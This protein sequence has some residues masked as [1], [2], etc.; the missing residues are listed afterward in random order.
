MPG[1]R[2][3]ALL[4]RGAVPRTAGRDGGAELSGPAARLCRSAAAELCTTQ[5]WCYGKQTREPAGASGQGWSCC[6][7]FPEPARPSRFCSWENAGRA[8]C[9][10]SGCWWDRAGGAAPGPCVPGARAFLCAASNPV[11][12][13]VW[14]KR[15]TC[16]LAGNSLRVWQLLPP[17]SCDLDRLA[18]YFYVSEC[19]LIRMMQQEVFWGG[20]EGSCSVSVR[21]PCFC[22][23]GSWRKWSRKLGRLLISSLNSILLP[24]AEVSEMCRL[25][26]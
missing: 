9:R 21:E 3:T 25:P 24:K 17:C 26:R 23:V 14:L 2:G 4:S 10:G 12:F 22:V 18:R 15:A 16:Q 7:R 1:Q 6:R 11:L 19:F 13:A 20:R 8:G 5:H